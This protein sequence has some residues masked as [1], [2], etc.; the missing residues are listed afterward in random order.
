[1]HAHLKAD[2]D[3]AALADLSALV[4]AA[5][6]SLAESAT[7]LKR[8]DP[9]TVW[10]VG[11]HPGLVGSQKAFSGPTFESLIARTAFVGE[12]GLEGT[13]RVPMD[14]QRATF[15]SILNTLQQ[16]PR[17]VSIHSN[18]ATGEVLEELEGKE[19]SG[20]ILH[21]WLGNDQQTRRAVQL[22]CYF[23]V[24]ASM[25]RDRNAIGGLP[26]S[27]VLPETDHPFGDRFDRGDRRPG[28]TTTV[29]THMGAKFGLTAAQMRLQMWKNLEQLVREA[30]VIDLLPRMVKITLATM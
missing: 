30:G 10:G 27:R 16:M 26:L 11:C 19:I 7:A 12:V 20:A 6:R 22:G 4:F 25:A 13:S 24:N 9:W 15:S 8:S 5:T 28:G 21:W 17:I 23:S 1:M 2:I 18:A 3:S 14:L 29:E